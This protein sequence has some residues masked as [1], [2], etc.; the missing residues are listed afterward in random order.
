MGG[1]TF[2]PDLISVFYSRER[3][4]LTCP[5]FFLCAIWLQGFSSVP[6]II[7]A[8]LQSGL[9]LFLVAS[10][11]SVFVKACLAQLWC[12]SEQEGFKPLPITWCWTSDLPAQEF[13]S[14]AVVLME[15]KQV[16]GSCLEIVHV[17]QVRV[18]VWAPAWGVLLET[19][20]ISQNCH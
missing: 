13:E 11:V 4:L 7:S 17:S 20:E 9:V 15:E 2:W 6:P 12:R 3:L 14:R 1:W 10:Q 5:H 8:V 19:V 18:W 16:L